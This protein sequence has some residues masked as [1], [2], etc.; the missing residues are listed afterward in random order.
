M[1]TRTE[2]PYVFDDGRT[3]TVEHTDGRV[4]ETAPGVHVALDG[5]LA[6]GQRE[7]DRLR[8]FLNGQPLDDQDQID[9]LIKEY[10]REKG[11]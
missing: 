9:A 7:P 6:P 3:I 5:T 1:G 8:Y 10:R 2:G 11:L 4:D